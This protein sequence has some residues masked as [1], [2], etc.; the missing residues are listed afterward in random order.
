MITSF[1]SEMSKELVTFFLAMIPLIE[2]KGAISIAVLKFNLAPQVAF[3]YSVMG[4]TVMSVVVFVLLKFL[5]IKAI[6]KIGFIDKLWKNSVGALRSRSRK[7]FKIGEGLAILFLS[8]VPV[9][10][11]G[12]FVAAI[13]AALLQTNT[14]RAISWLILGNFLS[15][16]VVLVVLWGLGK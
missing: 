4:S 13:L 6:V 12:S 3:V 1:F 8:V 16:G 7:K 14:S 9:P 5:L 2:L 10:G 15:G 11:L